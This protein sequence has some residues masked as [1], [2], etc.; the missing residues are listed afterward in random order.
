MHETIKH[1]KFY[2]CP[3]TYSAEKL[4]SSYNEVVTCNDKDFWINA[5]VEEINALR[6]NQTSV[7]VKRSVNRKVINSEFTRKRKKQEKTNPDNAQQFKAWLIIKGYAQI[8]GF[9]Y[10]N[11]FNP[12]VRYDT[13][14]FLLNF[15]ALFWSIWYKYSI[16]V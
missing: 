12:V 13:V 9:D 10:K 15:A 11:T 4:P 14:K 8:Q 7:L 3:V 2:G 6:E 1:T 16:L 5:M